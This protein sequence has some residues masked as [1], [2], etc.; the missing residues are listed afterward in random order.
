MLVPACLFLLSSSLVPLAAC[1]EDPQ[2]E[3]SSDASTNASSSSGG[4]SG[5]SSGSAEAGAPRCHEQ[6]PAAD[7]PHFLVTAHPYSEETDSDG[8]VLATRATT[9]KVHAIDDDG[10]RYVA[11]FE[12]GGYAS[13]GQVAFTP[14]GR[15]GAVA[16]DSRE[17]NAR[18]TVG[19]FQLD[20]RGTPK[21][22]QAL[23][24]GDFF[25]SQVAFSPDGRY[26]YI[27]DTNTAKNGGGV[28]VAAIDCEGK[29]GAAVRAIS[30]SGSTVP[31]WLGTAAPYRALVATT[32]L[33]GDDDN[34][35]VEL[36]EVNGPTMTR[37]S[38]ADPFGD[39][40]LISQF[41]TTVDG[42]FTLMTT[43]NELFGP[44]RVYAVKL[45]ED[46]APASGGA[47]DRPGAEGIVVSPF[48]NAVFV[49]SADP[50]GAYTMTHDPANTTEP[51]GAPKEIAYGA[52]GRP[53]LPAYAGVV[54]RGP[55]KGRI[56]ITENTT[57]RQ[58]QFEADGRVTDRGSVAIEGTHSQNE[59][60]AAG[61]TP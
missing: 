18:G 53:E 26:L 3:V 36:F 56:V 34:Q 48:A 31:M 43:H 51:F 54:R 47:F 4:S 60:G 28:Y 30:G 44:A 10:A 13:F 40:A 15:I 61:L 57:I 17:E 2:E 7:A 39:K 9:F 25:A 50:N 35:P 59:I 33:L 24:K 1:G 5:G 20:E 46:G 55:L 29:P 12:L 27:A 21:V 32:D 23:Y 8:G 58:L 49:T 11:D 19:I 41:A 22:V 42:R 45:D 6:P 16:L 38:G 52:D 37:T 14:D